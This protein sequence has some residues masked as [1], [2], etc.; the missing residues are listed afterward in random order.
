MHTDLTPGPNGESFVAAS[1]MATSI[2]VFTAV[3]GVL[4]HP[5]S[6]SCAEA[7]EALDLLAARG[8]PVV[9]MSHGDAAAV[10]ALQQELGLQYPFICRSG[11][12]LYI[13][14]GYFEELDG[15][16]SGD[17]A[18]EIFQFG[19]RD[20]SRAVRLLASLYSVRG[21]EILTIGFGCSAEDCGLLTAVHVP[22]I[23]R[24]A[25]A[26]TT[27]LQRRVPEAYV[28]VAAGPAGWNEAVLGSA[29]V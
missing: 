18:W 24:Q 23:V 19:V 5:E 6:G 15:L 26:D 27:R 16:T 21:E 1:S 3:D 20:P 29:A 10:E 4:R 17:D 14:R 9:L 13:P 22:I 11:A 25:G 2:V 28:T 12:L 7:R 8:V